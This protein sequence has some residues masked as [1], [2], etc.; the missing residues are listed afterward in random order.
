[1]T[2]RL[3]GL[4]QS[5]PLVSFVVIN[6][7]ISW[8]F[9]YPCYRILL[10]EPRTFRPL[11]LI[12]LI[13][14]YGPSIAALLV[15]AACGGR[16]TVRAALRQFL[17][18]RQSA[19]WYLFV[20][21]L[22]VCCY[23]IAVLANVRRNL[24]PGGALLAAPA[25]FL[26]ALP[27]GRLG[28]ELGWRGYFLPQLLERYSAARSTIV[29]GLVWS[30]WH[31]VSFTFPGAAIPSF[32]PVGAWSIF[33]FFLSLTAESFVF[34]YV[35]LKTRARLVLATLL[36]MSFNA[37]GNI[38]ASFVP[39]LQTEN[40]LREAIYITNIAIVAVLAIGFWMLDLWS[41][42]RASR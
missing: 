37:S 12:G 20:I 5:H 8:A 23:L 4:I 32:F 18:F 26:L 31:L 14:A 28:E 11:A 17:A 30:A 9:L 7:T 39:S 40:G 16:T 21:F 27:F 41:R 13:G 6:Y 25:A 34:T 3:T 19:G 22:P 1:M 29:V 38:A 10:Q 36:H 42:R 2:T 33:L 15:L 35:Y 24:H